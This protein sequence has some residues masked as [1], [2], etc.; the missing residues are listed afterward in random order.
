MPH[1]GARPIPL[2]PAALALAFALG[3]PS[4]DDDSSDDDGP[5][6]DLLEALPTCAGGILS[7]LTMD[8]M[9]PP[10]GGSEGYDRPSAAT[11]S[12]FRTSVEALLGGRGDDAITAA[13]EAG[14]ELC[15]GDGGELDLARWRPVGE[16]GGQA[17]VVFRAT[18]ARPLILGNPHSWLE[19]GTL[20]EC[21]SM[22]DR[23]DARAL[24]V[25]GTHRCANDSYAECDGTTSVCSESTDRYRESDMAHVVD[26]VFQVAH[27]ALAGHFSEDWVISVHG[28]YL[29]GISLS[30]GTSNPADAGDPVALFGTALMEA[31]PGDEVTSCNE[32]PGADVSVRFC[33]TTNVQGRHVNGASSPCTQ[34]A[35]TAVGRF[36]HLEQTFGIWLN[37]DPVVDA[38]DSVV[39]QVP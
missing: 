6:A 35:T 15:R 24:I 28:F 9:D 19:Y 22:F 18:G 12:A 14:Y 31:Y 25:T 32:F 36:M 23:I 1:S 17:H 20:D 7:S 2:L 13:Q 39:P 4:D 29:G 10:L 34:P 5:P 30:D 8:A 11:L 37:P 21:V 16:D 33:G 26:S 38:L 27:E 3:C